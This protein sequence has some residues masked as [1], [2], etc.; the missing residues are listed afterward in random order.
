MNDGGLAPLDPFIESGLLPTE[1]VDLEQ[2]TFDEPVL[3]EDEVPT[4]N[5]YVYALPAAKLLGLR[6]EVSYAVADKYIVIMAYSDN[7]D[8]AAAVIRALFEQYGEEAAQ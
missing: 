7:Q 2:V 8:T 3:F 6:K 1:G 5:R 4:G